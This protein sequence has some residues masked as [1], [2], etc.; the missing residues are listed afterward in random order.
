MVGKKEFQNTLVKPS[1]VMKRLKSASNSRLR[2]FSSIKI[3]KTNNTYYQK[4]NNFPVPKEI[5]MAVIAILFGILVVLGTTLAAFS[6]LSS[7]SLKQN[8]TVGTFKILFTEGQVILL[9]NTYPMSDKEGLAITPYTFQM[10]NEGTITAK[11]QVRLLL[12]NTNT[13]VLSQDKIKISYNIGS[14]DSTP[15][16]LSQGNGLLVDQGT[17]V[18][19]ATI[20][21]NLRLWI[22]ELAGNEVQGKTFKAKIVIDAVQ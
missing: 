9:N 16:I 7:A 5:I 12:D 3:N 1:K 18:S 21:Y 6:Q 2:S 14:V 15:R 10:K 4:T 19:G 20:I 22:D 13:N 11:Y 8:M 17:L